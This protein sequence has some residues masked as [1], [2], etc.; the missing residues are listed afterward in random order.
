MQ[1]GRTNTRALRGY[2]Q[3]Q[4]ARSAGADQQG[5]EVQRAAKR[6]LHAG[7]LPVE[8]ACGV[9]RA[10]GRRVVRGWTAAL[11]YR[12]GVGI[13]GLNCVDRRRIQLLQSPQQKVTGVAMV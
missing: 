10:D 5:V 2:G 12:R 8:G 13:A 6:A 7:K 4:F 11:R 1:R 9:L 3:C